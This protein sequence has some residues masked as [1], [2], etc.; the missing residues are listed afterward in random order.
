MA[1]MPRLKGKSTRV[2]YEIM[3][4]PAN[5]KKQKINRHQRKI[6]ELL[7]AEDTQRVR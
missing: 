2:A 5:M 1:T 4:T 6:N 7:I 3:G